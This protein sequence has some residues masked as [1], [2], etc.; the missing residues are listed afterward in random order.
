MLSR[1]GRLFLRGLLPGAL[2]TLL[3]LAL[4]ILLG[5]SVY[6]TAAE[7]AVPVKTALVDEEDDFLSR[8]AISAVQNEPYISAVLEFKRMSRENALAAL[9]TG[10]VDAVVLLPSGY[11][12][13][14]R[15]GRKAFGEI[16]LSDA[17][18]TSAEV[19][20]A[21]ASFGE[22]LLVSG[23]QGVFT[24]EE[25][26]VR[27]G[28]SNEIHEAFIEKSN[29]EL[30]DVVFDLFGSASEVRVT[31]YDGSGLS[32][33][34]CTAV[35]WGSFFFL[36]FGLFFTGLYTLDLRRELVARLYAGGL[37]PFGFLFGKLLY[38]FAGRV[39]IAVPVLALLSNV[40]PLSVRFSGVL[41]F[42]AG[43]LIATV[44]ST[45]GVV[46]LSDR[47]GAAGVLAAVFSLGLFLS[48]GLIPRAMLPDLIPETGRFLPVG[49]LNGFFAPLFGGPADVPAMICGAVLAAGLLILTHR[50]LKSVPEKGGAL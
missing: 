2:F 44:F 14:I 45:C 7:K 36:L 9:E 42:I 23:Q 16:H 47:R 19:I 39:M 27:E 46:L 25:L 8:A 20:R 43:L 29:A 1:D 35:T 6:R 10:D 12:D 11:L 49:I 21:I 50:K 13:D 24:G 4:C 34:A 3:S 30:I 33:T 17:A 18:A 48:G 38:P 28:L 31:D 5:Y 32:V 26:I 22:L 41:L 15:G 37:T 40:T